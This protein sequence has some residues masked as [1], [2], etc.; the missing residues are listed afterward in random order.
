MGKAW[1]AAAPSP[2]PGCALDALSPVVRS[3]PPGLWKGT[4]SVA[5]AALGLG[6]AL[7]FRDPRWVFNLELMGRAPATPLLESGR[8]LEG[9]NG[10]E[11][12]S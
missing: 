5:S 4:A 7:D 9:A 11:E 6:A 2:Q 3:C 12:G 8:P 1:G 10:E